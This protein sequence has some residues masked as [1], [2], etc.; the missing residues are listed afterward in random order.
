M[1]FFFS[2]EGDGHHHRVAVRNNRLQGGNGEAD[3]SKN[4]VHQR[5]KVSTATWEKQK[6]K[7]KRKQ[8]NSSFPLRFPSLSLS[9]RPLWKR[10][11]RDLNL[12]CLILCP[13]LS[14]F[15]FKRHPATSI[16][17]SAHSLPSKKKIP[18][19]PV[20]IAHFFFFR[21]KRKKKTNIKKN[22]ILYWDIA[23]SP[24]PG[25]AT[26]YYTW[27][28]KKFKKINTFLKNLFWSISM[29]WQS[30]EI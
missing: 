3:G 8:A 17:E 21:K 23:Y 11:V 13:S 15:F 2:S 16:K 12:L 9:L 20:S 1:N 24:L 26:L 18:F 29:L 7:K 28:K 6:K 22:K 14:L 25:P 5:I 30:L 19:L 4:K 10:K 27:P